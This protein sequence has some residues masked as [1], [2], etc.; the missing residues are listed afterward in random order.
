M[1]KS[2]AASQAFAA[3]FL[4]YGQNLMMYP[5][6]MRAAILEAM[7]LGDD[8]KVKEI[9]EL[10]TRWAEYAIETMVGNEQKGIEGM[11]VAVRPGIDD[12]EVIAQAVRNFQKTKFYDDL[13]P[14]TKARIERYAQG[15]IMML[16]QGA[17]LQGQAEGG[18]Q[19]PQQE[20][21]NATTDK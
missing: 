15:Q 13:P 3:E 21:G 18:G 8:S 4:Q 1:P 14:E 12:H 5:P 11:D 19:S 20:G 9:F 16:V 2:K 10:D 17:A 6:L 7:E